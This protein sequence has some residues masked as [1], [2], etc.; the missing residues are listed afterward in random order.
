MKKFLVV[1]LTVVFCLAI[2]GLVIADEIAGVTIDNDVVYGGGSANMTAD[3]VSGTGNVEL[4]CEQV[5][6]E[7]ETLNGEF[8]APPNE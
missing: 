4:T 1:L 5:E 3:G 6:L 8:T 2:S 7:D